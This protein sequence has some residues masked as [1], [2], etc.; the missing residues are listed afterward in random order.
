MR[1]KR[2]IRT[3]AQLPTEADRVANVSKA[4]L[5]R[6]TTDLAGSYNDIAAA[7]RELGRSAA[8]AAPSYAGFR[9]NEIEQ[10]S[11]R[12]VKISAMRGDGIIA[13]FEMRQEDYDH[14][15]STGQLCPGAAIN[16]TQHADTFERFLIDGRVE[17]MAGQV[18]TSLE[19]NHVE[20]PIELLGFYIR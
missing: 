9:V 17:R 13:T 3:R 6:P 2:V 15:Q 7:F 12:R 4:P 8:R 14:L 5:A 1:K 10:G 11:D 20:L 19:V 18:T 16:I